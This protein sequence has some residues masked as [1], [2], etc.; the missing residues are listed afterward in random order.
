MPQETNET[1]SSGH[2]SVIYKTS[3]N[4]IEKLKS[5]C[6][7]EDLKYIKNPEI[8][9]GTEVESSRIITYTLDSQNKYF[10]TITAKECHKMSPS[11]KEEV[12]NQVETRQ[13]LKL[14]KTQSTDV[15]N[16]NDIE[17]V[18][19]EIEKHDSTEF[20]R[21]S[22]LTEKEMAD[23]K[24]KSFSNA[25]N[26]FRDNLKSNLLGSLA[27]TKAFLQLVSIARRSNK[28][29]ISKTLAIK[30]NQKIM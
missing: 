6:Q 25:V 20:T 7:S 15:F 24:I 5:N 23:E 4:K 29:D 13:N 12:G 19:A 3:P 16:G 11:V 10:S 1:D 28:E 2:C 14:I 18:L 27:P 8:V 26:D 9:L 30:K 21:E 22:L 17:E